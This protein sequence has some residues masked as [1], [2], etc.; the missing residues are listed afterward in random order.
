MRGGIREKGAEGPGEVV[1][2]LVANR[3]TAPRPLYDVAGWANAYATNEWLGTPGALLN[4]DRLG[5]ALDAVENAVDPDGGGGAHPDMQIGGP[6]RD[7]QLQQ[8]RH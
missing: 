3:L 8:I 4:D 7:H 2:A 6:F 5:R 1:A